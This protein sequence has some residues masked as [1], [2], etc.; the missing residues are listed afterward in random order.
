ML[1]WISVYYQ[2][3]PQTQFS[4]QEDSVAAKNQGIYVMIIHVTHAAV[5]EKQ[6]PKRF[7][8]HFW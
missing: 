8:E 7:E 4:H 2:G 6:I 3:K 1:I 5:H